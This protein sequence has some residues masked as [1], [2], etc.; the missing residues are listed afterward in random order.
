MGAVYKA[1][2]RGPARWVGDQAPLATSD[3][4]LVLRFRRE[5]ETAAA[6]QHANIV[7]D[8]RR[9]REQRAAVPGHEVRR[10]LHA[11]GMSVTVDQACAM[12]LQA[13]AGVAVAHKSEIVHRD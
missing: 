12:T 11:V 1:W 5:A 3:P 2:D 7:P 9:R 6:V 10:G 8:L 4:Q 13:A